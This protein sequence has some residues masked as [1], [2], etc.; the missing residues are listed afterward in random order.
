MNIIK[1][2]LRNPKRLTYLLEEVLI[3]KDPMGRYFAMKII[4]TVAG[5]KGFEAE[6]IASLL[7]LI[8]VIEYATINS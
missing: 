4:A 2:G 6:K 3:G 7:P 8:K 5:N 1:E